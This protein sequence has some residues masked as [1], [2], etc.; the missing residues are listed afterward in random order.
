LKAR[1]LACPFG[2]RGLGTRRQACGLTG[3]LAGK[4]LEA[5]PPEVRGFIDICKAFLLQGG[6]PKKHIKI[7]QKEQNK[8]FGNIDKKRIDCLLSK[9]LTRDKYLFKI[10]C[11]V[12]KFEL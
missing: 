12:Y 3:E 2:G 8:R 1:R 9:L 11:L 4:I 10:K 6:T 5:R 7:S